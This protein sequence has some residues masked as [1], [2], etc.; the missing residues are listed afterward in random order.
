MTSITLIAIIGL[1]VYVIGVSALTAQANGR[2][3]RYETQ[4][5][6]AYN[7]GLGIAPETPTIGPLHLS[8]SVTINSD[9][10]VTPVVD[11]IVTVT[12]TGPNSTAHEIGPI[13]LANNPLDLS[14]YETTVDI[15]RIGMWSFV[16]DIVS[17]Y[18]SARTR[19]E[20]TVQ[21]SNPLIGLLALFVLVGLITVLGI[22]FR[23]YLQQRRSADMKSNL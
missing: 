23:S 12:G 15:P 9:E 4:A 7:I 8:V 17:D 1:L 13:E 10:S 2:I 5:V 21:E 6:G 22:A 14:V 18:G 11:A 20:V 16:F 19:F 3:L